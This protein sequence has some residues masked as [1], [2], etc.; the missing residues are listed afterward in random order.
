MPT[1]MLYGKQSF[2]DRAGSDLP[3]EVLHLQGRFE[4]LTLRH[5]ASTSAGGLAARP[6]CWL[7]PHR[8]V[9]S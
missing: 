4:V 9:L 6:V 8:V 1:S 2:V 7:N 3:M 5:Q